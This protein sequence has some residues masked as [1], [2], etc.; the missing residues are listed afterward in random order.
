MTHPVF[1]PPPP[2]QAASPNSFLSVSLVEDHS[3]C[4]ARC[5][6]NTLGCGIETSSPHPLL[7]PVRF[8][9]GAQGPVASSLSTLYSAPCAHHQP[10]QAAA[11]NSILSVSLVEGR[12]ACAARFAPNTLGCGIKANSPPPLPPVRFT[13]GAQGPVAGSLSTL[14][15]APF[16]HPA[17]PSGVSKLA[18]L[19]GLLV[20]GSGWA[21]LRGRKYEAHPKPKTC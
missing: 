18:S 2:H 7:P 21:S 15:P 12:P 1:R 14:Y 17:P 9:H 13:H 16:A 10:R 8:T 3:A 19:F 5:A 4:A 6:P 20:S 11:A